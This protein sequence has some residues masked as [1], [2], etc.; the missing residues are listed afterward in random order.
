MATPNHI[1]PRLG[2]IAPILPAITLMW[3]SAIPAGKRF[4]PVD[5]CAAKPSHGS[6]RTRSDDELRVKRSILSLNVSDPL[7]IKYF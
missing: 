7:K 3:R 1:L 6:L 5:V 4:Q 2:I